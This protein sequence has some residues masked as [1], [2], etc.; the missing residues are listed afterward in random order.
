MTANDIEGSVNQVFTQNRYYTFKEVAE[1]LNQKSNTLSARYWAKIAKAYEGSMLTLRTSDG[2]T[3]DGANA[4]AQYIQL[5]VEGGLAKGEYEALIRERYG[6][7]APKTNQEYEQFDA[8][9]VD[10]PSPSADV[11]L[12]MDLALAKSET[13]LVATQNKVDDLLADLVIKHQSV[14]QRSAQIETNELRSVYEEERQKEIL[15]L[16]ARQ[17]ARE[18]VQRDFLDAME[19]A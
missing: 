18:D 19:D 1:K 8:E 17:R 13:R 14:A 16:M 4:I 2:L 9:F 11:P 7:D 10:D 15:R 3:M 6:I 12:S 5:V